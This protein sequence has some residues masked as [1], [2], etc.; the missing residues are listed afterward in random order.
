[1]FQTKGVAVSQ[2]DPSLFA[3]SKGLGH[4]DD[5]KQREIA[6]IEAQVY[7]YA[8]LLGVRTWSRSNIVFVFMPVVYINCGYS[9]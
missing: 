8:E 5:K 7:K 6:Y 4:H 2:L 9:S 3:K 1:M